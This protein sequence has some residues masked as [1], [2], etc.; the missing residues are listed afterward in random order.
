MLLKIYRSHLKSLVGDVYITAVKWIS[1]FCS[2]WQL[3]CPTQNEGTNLW[4][5]NHFY[6]LKDWPYIW[7]RAN[8]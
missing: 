5:S 2:P 6:Q 1:Y 7:L 3:G 4:P 8:Q